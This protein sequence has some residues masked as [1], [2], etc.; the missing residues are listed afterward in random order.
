MKFSVCI[1]QGYSIQL[2]VK[3]QKKCLT[4]LGYIIYIYHNNTRRLQWK[5]VLDTVGKHPRP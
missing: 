3:E 2:H 5:T 1:F 4:Q